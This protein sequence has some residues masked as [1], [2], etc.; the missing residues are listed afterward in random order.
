MTVHD[1]LATPVGVHECATCK[2]CA[3]TYAIVHLVCPKCAERDRVEAE[4]ARLK[5]QVAA[6]VLGFDGMRQRAEA[7]EA[8]VA[9]L[10][11]GLRRIEQMALRDE[12]GIVSVARSLLADQDG[13]ARTYAC[14]CGYPGPEPCNGCP[15]GCKRRPAGVTGW[16][17]IDNRRGG[18]A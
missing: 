18:A 6:D 15:D 4:I 12:S 10:R 11:D 5:Q 9:R 16:D 2:R 17:H 14:P 13:A 1:D 3:T 7:A 8:E